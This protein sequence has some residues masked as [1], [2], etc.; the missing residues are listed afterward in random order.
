MAGEDWSIGRNKF[1]KF[2]I[3]F[4]G[5]SLNSVQIHWILNF[6]SV[7]NCSIGAAIMHRR[8]RSSQRQMLA[9]NQL[10]ETRIVYSVTAWPVQLLIEYP[11]DDYLDVHQLIDSTILYHPSYPK[12]APK[13]G[14]MES[15]SL[16]VARWSEPCVRRYGQEGAEAISRKTFV[17][18]VFANVKSS[19]L[20]VMKGAVCARPPEEPLDW[21]RTTSSTSANDVW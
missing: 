7:R 13:P 4:S 6:L 15:R 2:D 16:V 9:T 18:K 19:L 10:A 14:N 5:K 8:S 17:E 21:S 1:S 11:A 12:R 20:N 3:T